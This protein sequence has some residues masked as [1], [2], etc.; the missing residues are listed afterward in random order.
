LNCPRFLFL[1]AGDPWP[2]RVSRGGA[3]GPRRWRISFDDACKPVEQP[4]LNNGPYVIHRGEPAATCVHEAGHAVAH[5]CAG[6]RIDHI[7]VELRFVRIWGGVVA[8]GAC[9]QCVPKGATV[10]AFELRATDFPLIRTSG[11]PP[12]SECWRGSL[13]RA[14]FQYAGPAAE[15]KFR[16]QSGLV[17]MAI[18]GPDA[19]IVERAARLVWLAQNRDGHAFMRMVWRLDCRLMDDP[20]V[21]KAVEAVEGELFSGLLRLEP[22]DPRPGDRVEFVMPGERAEELI[23]GAGIELPD[24]RAPHVCS[25][26]CIRPSRKISRRWQEYLADWGA[27][28]SKDAA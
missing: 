17:R 23:A 26:E 9:G 11:P 2:G 18:K 22:M 24:I 20:E 14:I 28:G 13:W 15:M 27:E 16:M 3:S 1:P 19:E 4:V 12:S 21:W 8:A 10:D 6:G 5:V 7:K 25:P